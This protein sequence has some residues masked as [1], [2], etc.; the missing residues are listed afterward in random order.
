M[1]YANHE[2]LSRGGRRIRREALVAADSWQR[3]REAGRLS[4]PSGMGKLAIFPSNYTTSKSNVSEKDQRDGFRVE[5]EMLAEQRL[6]QHQ[7][8][9]VHQAAYNG[10]IKAA[11]RD[12]EVTDIIVIGHGSIGCFWADGF[13]KNF[14]WKDVAGA[15][16][17]LKQGRFEQRTCGSFRTAYNVPLG[18]FAVSQLENVIAAPGKNL[19]DLGVQD[20]AFVPVFQPGAETANDVIDRLN[21]LH[22]SY[23]GRPNRT[24]I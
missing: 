1:N 21:S 9:Q 24:G 14:N 15:T 3:K 5:A 23:A 19:P 20:S 11:L 12:P 22:D 4:L 18:T 2:Q 8:V 16:G 17:S 7:E 13:T 10:Q 6:G